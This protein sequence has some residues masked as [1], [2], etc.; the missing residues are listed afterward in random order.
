LTW[1]ETL[2]SGARTLGM[3]VFISVLWS[4]WSTESVAVWLSLWS[5]AARG[6]APGQGPTIA[7]ILAVPAA[8]VAWVIVTS[9]GWLRPARQRSY[10]AGA[11]AMVATATC[12]ILLSSSVVYKHLGPAG[13]LIASVRYGGLN[14]ADAA[15]LERG[16]YENLMAGNRFN[17][18]LWALYMNRPPDW[19]K[20]ITELG[21]ARPAG[22]ALP[23]EL[24]P[25]LDAHFK[26]A[27]FR[28]NRWGMH[29]KEY[30]L[31]RPAEC[32]RIAV[33][34]ASHAMGTGVERSETFE[35]VLEN[36]LNQD[37]NGQ[38]SR[39]FEVLNFAV[40]GYNPIDQILVLEG[41][42]AAFDP[43]AILY[44][45]HPEDSRR[46]ARYLAKKVM[47]GEVPPHAELSD[48]AR[49][50]DVDRTTQERIAT[51]RLAPL[52][53]DILASVHRQLAAFSRSRGICPAWMFL[54]M[55]PEL[56]YTVDV[57]AEKRTAREAGF[58]V[59]DLGDVYDRVNRNTLW[60][61]E[62]DGHPN[63]QAHRLI[64]DRLYALI[65]GRHSDFLSCKGP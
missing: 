63:A 16:Y 60:V 50:A 24:V 22:N 56:T 41:R 17:G 46:V 32:Y 62:W 45:G 8:V 21:F 36:R 61:A 48:I 3:F 30:T 39:C 18:E 2:I 53:N 54:P 19:A 37:N 6:P 28:T 35:A 4:L 25:G 47:A 7:L 9:R 52:G 38:G 51:Q 65:R 29:D 15:N 11:V 27:P 12:L 26:G 5:A 58:V 49:A 10:E 55:V 20:R 42:V 1:R 43:N 44:V 57:E 13:P 34:G 33:L 64:G 14:Q 59:L 40:W 31:E 23:Y